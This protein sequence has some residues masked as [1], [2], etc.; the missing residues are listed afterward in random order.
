[1]NELEPQCPTFWHQGLVSWEIIFP[2]IRV[3]GGF[4]PPRVHYI[5]YAATDLTRGGAQ[6][7]MRET[8]AAVNTEKASFSRLLL[9]SCC[10]PQFLTGHGPVPVCDLG[11][12]DP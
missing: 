7:V 5:Y 3:G 9:T 4:G 8:G 10:A 11:V 1:M 6:A 12:E 2:Q